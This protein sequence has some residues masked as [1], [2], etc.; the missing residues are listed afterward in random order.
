LQCAETEKIAGGT[1]AARDAAMERRS[2]ETMPTTGCPQCHA[3]TASATGKAYCPE[4]GWNRAEVEKRTRL[5]LRLLPILV[6]LFDAPLIIYIF[7]GHAEISVLAA[8][9]LL[10]IIPAILVRSVVRAKMRLPSVK[11]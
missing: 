10:A 1:P 5:F 9:A 7:L 6:I 3:P 4:C 8:L 2:L 11:D